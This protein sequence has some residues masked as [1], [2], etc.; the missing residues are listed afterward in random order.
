MDFPGQTIRWDVLLGSNCPPLGQIFWK[1]DRLNITL[2]IQENE[3]PQA[4]KVLERIQQDL[5]VGGFNVLVFSDAEAP[6][7]KGGMRLA[8]S[9]CWKISAV[10]N[11]HRMV[12]GTNDAHFQPC[13][14]SG[15]PQR[16]LAKDPEFKI[17]HLLSPGEQQSLW[18]SVPPVPGRAPPNWFAAGGQKMRLPPPRP[19]D[20]L[21]KV[22]NVISF[23]VAVGIA[24]K[25]PGC[26]T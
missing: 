24:L 15:T 9:L 22:T 13:L 11:V 20:R 21:P 14:L 1:D 10:L 5:S 17:V 26:W 4:A 7:Y 3:I 23:N 16:N 8:N 6:L 12:S 2:V 19:I 18:V 25:A